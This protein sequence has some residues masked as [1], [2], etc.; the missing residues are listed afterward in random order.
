[1]TYYPVSFTKDRP[2]LITIV[3][4]GCQSLPPLSV[5]RGQWV[6]FRKSFSYCW[7]LGIM[8]RLTVH[9]SLAFPALAF[10]IGSCR[11]ENHPWSSAA[12]T[13]NLLVRSEKEVLLLLITSSIVLAVRHPCFLPINQISQQHLVMR[14][15]YHLNNTTRLTGKSELRGSTWLPSG[16]P[17]KTFCFVLQQPLQL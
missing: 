14:L 7:L 4:H 17:A 16:G 5:V 8:M 2:H 3:E 6:D 1:M 11:G 9:D 10:L 15:S 12:L 13:A